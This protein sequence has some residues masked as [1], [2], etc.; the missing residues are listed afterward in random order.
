MKAWN[1]QLQK[2]RRG[3]WGVTKPWIWSWQIAGYQWLSLVTSDFSDDHVRRILLCQ[4][5]V[6]F[7]G[8]LR[9]LRCLRFRPWWRVNIDSK[10]CISLCESGSF[11]SD[12]VCDFFAIKKAA[13]KVEMQPNWETHNCE[14][15]H[16][17]NHYAILCQLQDIHNVGF[18]EMQTRRTQEH[19]WIW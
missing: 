13:Y 3:I 11:S 4:V 8:W 17:C 14:G 9:S 12:S 5:L 19:V 7:A 16:G 1:W 6:S 18:N 2:V 10:N 15:E